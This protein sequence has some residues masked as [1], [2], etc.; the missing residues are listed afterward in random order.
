M[1]AR[2]EKKNIGGESQ[3]KIWRQQQ[4]CVSSDDDK[5][6]AAPTR[7]VENV[8]F[9]VCNC[10]L[11]FRIWSFCVCSIRITFNSEEPKNIFAG[12]A[13]SSLS[14]ANCC[15]PYDELG[16][17]EEAEYEMSEENGWDG[18]NENVRFHRHSRTVHELTTTTAAKRPKLMSTR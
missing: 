15:L 8:C 12:R 4:K 1:R 2:R 5:P 13:R 16:S 3:K 18:M 7:L 6:T 10:Q 9:S 14:F 11:S 17:D